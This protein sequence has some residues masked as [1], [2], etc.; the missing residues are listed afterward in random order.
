MQTLHEVVDQHRDHCFLDTDRVTRD[1]GH[2]LEL[3][4]TWHAGVFFKL[5]LARLDVAYIAPWYSSVST[6]PTM[7][8]SCASRC[9]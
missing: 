3:M 7:I 6:M 4:A 1:A 9:S 5:Q 8:L 2:M